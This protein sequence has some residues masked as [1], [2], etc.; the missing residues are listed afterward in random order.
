MTDGATVTVAAVAAGTAAGALDEL[1]SMWLR[2]AVE[3]A[4]LG[5]QDL[6]EP[7]QKV[8]VT[9][10]MVAAVDNMWLSV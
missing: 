6:E 7:V 3:L 9:T 2:L 4:A 5:L 8:A 1:R 10:D